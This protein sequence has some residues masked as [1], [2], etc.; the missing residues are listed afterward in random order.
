[1]VG[2]LDISWSEHLGRGCQVT[3]LPEGF[4]ASSNPQAGWKQ[5]GMFKVE[6]EFSLLLSDPKDISPPL[7][8]FFLRT[9]I[10]PCAALLGM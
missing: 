10:C 2:K 7:F 3:A 1:M 8:F 6:D 9:K 4:D 5:Q